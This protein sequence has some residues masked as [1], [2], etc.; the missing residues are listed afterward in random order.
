MKTLSS[1]EPAV[2]EQLVREFD[3]QGWHRTGSPGDN[4][5][6][7]WLLEKLAGFGVHGEA[8]PF[9]FAKLDVGSAL[10]E[11][12]GT[13]IAGHAQMDA[14][15]TP[16]GGQLGRL[17]TAARP[18]PGCIAVLDIDAAGGG[19]DVDAS[20]DHCER[21]GAAGL[22]VIPR[23]P[24]GSMFIMNARHLSWPWPLPVL[25]IPPADAGPLVNGLAAGGQARLVIE[26]R[27]R[28]ASATNVVALLPADAP[29][30][31]ARVLGVMTPKSGWFTCAAERGGGLI[32]WLAAAEMAART[33]GRAHD[34]L[35]LATAGHELGHA[36]LEAYLLEHPDMAART[37][38]WIHLGAS[39]GA[40]VQPT[41]NVFASTPLLLDSLREELDDA[42]AG[43][44]RLA[45]VGLAP[46]GEARNIALRGGRFVSLAGGHAFFHTP[47]DRPDKVD[48]VSVSRYAQAVAALVEMWVRTAR[49]TTP[50]HLSVGD[51]SD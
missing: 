11:V 15:L 24:H 42:G 30:P 48:P 22:V 28:N 20:I 37:D 47:E 36:G 27:R 21:A 4:A 2:I 23:R 29:T 39:I 16:V 51:A 31:N 26:G 13:T 6:T 50:P 49:M 44:Y 34:V 17:T 12:G 43:P 3:D 5:T 41:L 8:H 32:A 14:G 33:P 19:H 46:G 25:F 38:P 35:L 18:E 7:T 40:A 9:L 10:I 1:A 45:P